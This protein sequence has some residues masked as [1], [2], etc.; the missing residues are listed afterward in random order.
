MNT[1]ETTTANYLEFLNTHTREDLVDTAVLAIVE[2]IKAPFL[3][4]MMMFATV[5]F[6][7]HLPFTALGLIFIKLGVKR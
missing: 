7:I 2:C 5:L 3:I 6:V 1:L 4:L